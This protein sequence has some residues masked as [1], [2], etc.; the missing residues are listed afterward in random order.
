M[1]LILEFTEELVLNLD[2]AEFGTNVLNHFNSMK[3]NKS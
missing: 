1:W 2:I 3:K